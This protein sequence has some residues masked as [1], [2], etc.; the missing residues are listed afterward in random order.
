MNYREIGLLVEAH[1]W[2]KNGDHPKDKSRIIKYYK[3]E[4]LLSE[5]KIIKRYRN[6]YN[7]GSNT[8]YA[9]NME[10]YDHGWIDCG[11]K[12]ITVCPK[13]WIIENISGEFTTCKPQLFN[14]SYMEVS[15]EIINN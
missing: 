15:Q 7:I 1:Q 3:G 10:M 14:S 4:E 13:D 11:G 2:F 5:G 6:P 12:G 9:C 8:C